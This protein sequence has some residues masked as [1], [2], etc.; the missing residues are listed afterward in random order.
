MND[1]KIPAY[2]V[3]Q[4]ISFDFALILQYVKEIAEELGIKKALEHLANVQA[5]N[6]AGW[7]KTSREA[8][9]NLS[10][11][12]IGANKVLKTFMKQVTPGWE[13]DSY[14]EVVHIPEQVVF[15]YTGYCPWLEACK[16]VGLQTKLVCPYVSQRASQASFDLLDE[17]IH[18]EITKFRPDSDYCEEV[19]TLK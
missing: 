7:F 12:A 5:S 19:I 18:I 10:Q 2:D 9:G 15:R 11:D 4:S 14:T 17:R 16:M 1:T 6:R 3:Q 13:A 8:I